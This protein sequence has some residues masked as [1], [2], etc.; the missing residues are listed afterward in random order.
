M[1]SHR[2][3]STR[4]NNIYRNMKKRCDNPNCPD[5][6]NY[7]GRG[8]RYCDKWKTFEGFWEDM[9]EGYSDE[10]TLDR[11]DVNKGYSKDNCRWVNRYVQANNT[12]VN[13]LFEYNGQKLTLRQ[14]SDTTGYDY[15]LIRLRI[16]K[17]WTLEQ[18]LS[19]A[20]EKETIIVDGIKRNLSDIAK[21]HGLS[22][23][24]LKKRLMRG[25]SIERAIGQ[26]LRKHH[27]Q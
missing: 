19:P 14:I 4:Q 5:Y 23:S 3:S 6:K 17:G 24:Q 8:I 18:S 2:M 25:W 9:Q 26:P 12:R 13:R 16:K 11:K 22:Y 21:E 10:L 7:G 20:K 15:E 1:A 27:A